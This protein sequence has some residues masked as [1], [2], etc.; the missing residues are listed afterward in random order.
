MRSSDMV[1]YDNTAQQLSSVSTADEYLLKLRGL[2]RALYVLGSWAP[3]DTESI[4]T[5]SAAG[6]PSARIVHGDHTITSPSPRT[7]PH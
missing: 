2:R 6:H 1:Q 3:S 7:T 4:R 5:P